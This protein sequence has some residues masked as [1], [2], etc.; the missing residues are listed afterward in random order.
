MGRESLGKF[1]SFTRSVGN[2]AVSTLPWQRRLNATNCVF[3][4]W[5]MMFIMFA[6]ITE[7]RYDSRKHLFV[8]V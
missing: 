2:H 4:L 8:N 3:H 6:G 7:G 1:H 5:Q